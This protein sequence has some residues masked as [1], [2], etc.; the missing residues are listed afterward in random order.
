MLSVSTSYHIA[1]ALTLNSSNYANFILII[2]L[3]FLKFKMYLCT[4]QEDI[5]LEPPASLQPGFTVV[6]NFVL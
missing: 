1:N 6:Y 2:L 4:S 5:I 3:S